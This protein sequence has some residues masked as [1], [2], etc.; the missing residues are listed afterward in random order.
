[1]TGERFEQT[2]RRI[3]LVAGPCVAVAIV[4]LGDPGGVHITGKQPGDAAPVVLPA[5]LALC[6]IWWITEALPPAVVALVAATGAVLTGL[7]TPKQAFG[8]LGSPLLF[9]FVGSFFIAEA[10]R[11]HGLGDRLARTIAAT[12]RT[13]RGLLTATALAAFTLS[14]WMS[15][16]ASTAILLPIVLPLVVAA[17]EPRFGAA[18]V[19][20]VAWGASVGGIGTPVGTPPNL[21]GLQAIRAGGHDISFLEWMGFGV[22]IGLVMLAAMLLVLMALL[23]VRDAPLDR[24]AVPPRAAW[25][26]GERSVLIAL[27]VAI[28]GWLTPTVLDLA[29]PDA[30]IT[31]WVDAHLTEEVAAVLGGLTLFALP[32]GPAGRAW[33]RPALVWSEAVRIDW[34]VIF[35]FGGGILLGDLAG[36]NGLSAQWGRAMVDATG[37]SSTWAI[38]A[39]VTAVAIVL[40][41]T[42]SNTA[43]ATLMAPLAGQLAIAAGGAP[44][45]AILG[46]TLGASFG[47]ML[48]IS[49]GP[50]AMAYGTGHVR[51]TQMIRGGIVFDVAGFLL[52]VGG[53][54]V[55][56]PLLGLA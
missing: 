22:P 13:R 40:S 45:P 53:L 43:T 44:V 24:A 56:C 30:R 27:G 20:S 19:L 18:M 4:L 2:L 55:M 31:G 5:L 41:E 1:V 7:A 46:A 35:L 28:V 8:A 11:I 29:A 32:G 26:P 21:I 48:P 23:G 52:I 37:V 39:L 9:L 54:R 25:S 34:G 33:S 14:L 47:F 50:N 49:T 17:N 6:V 42:T 12:A 38:T 16:S 10:M 3:G 15:N 36:Q 51:V